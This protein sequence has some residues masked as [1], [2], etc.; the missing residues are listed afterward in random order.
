MKKFAITI[1][2]IAAILFISPYF[3]GKTVENKY[4]TIIQNI[5][6]NPQFSIENSSFE[7]HWFNAKAVN[8]LVIPLRTN[9][10]NNVDFPKQLTLKI[11]ENINFGPA[12]LSEL[13]LEFG[14]ARSVAH[15]D[16][17]QGFLNKKLVEKI[18]KNLHIQS[19]VSFTNNYITDIKFDG[20]DT[21]IDDAQ[22]IIFPLVAKYAINNQR[23]IVANI[24]WQGLKTINQKMEFTLGTINAFMDEELVT[25]ELYS[26][27][28]LF[29]GDINFTI[30]SMT[31]QGANRNEL[32]T[33]KNITMKGGSKVSNNLMNILVSYHVDEI[34]LPFQHFKQA[35]LA[36]TLDH[37]DVDVMQLF[38]KIVATSTS[39]P[40]KLFTENS[41]QL[42]TATAQLLKKDPSFSITDLSVE[43]TSGKIQ[44]QLKLTVDKNR[45]NADNIKSFITAAKVDASGSAPVEFFQKMGMMPMVEHYIQQGFLVRNQGKLNFKMN[46][47]QGKLALNNK[48]LPL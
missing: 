42:L 33:F 1:V 21:Q 39:S 40:D 8:T 43:T 12:I 13:G 14:L 44:S 28:A 11:T 7:R 9:T 5:Q 32:F 48:V 41:K 31:A 38:N 20:I 10:A 30:A 34:N 35:N 19:F 3:V 29:N 22:V 47:E 36:L 15:V 46:F 18:N 24:N 2:V 17:N 6:K 23:H 26:N 27:T 37:L 4:Q 45:F 25:G 16:V